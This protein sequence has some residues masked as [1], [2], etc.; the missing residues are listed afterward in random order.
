MLSV[1]RSMGLWFQLI[2]I[3]YLKDEPWECW[4]YQNSFSIQNNSHIWKGFIRVLPWINHMFGWC[5]GDGASIKIGVDPIAG[6]KYHLLLLDDLRAYLYYYGI[7]N[8]SQARNDGEQSISS[9]YWLSAE[10]L[11]LEGSWK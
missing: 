11:E 6:L 3:K 7:S 5:V 2:H 10:D 8:L 1:L 4:I 9:S